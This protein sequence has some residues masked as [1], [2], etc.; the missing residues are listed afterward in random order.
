MNL[1]EFIRKND[2]KCKDGEEF[3]H[4]PEFFK[5]R[6]FERSCHTITGVP[7][8]ELGTYLVRD[9]DVV[10][11]GSVRERWDS[12]EKKTKRQFFVD[13]TFSYPDQPDW[14]ETIEDAVDAGQT[15]EQ[16]MECMEIE[17]QRFEF[18]REHD[19]ID[20]GRYWLDRK[21]RRC[22]VDKGRVVVIDSNGDEGYGR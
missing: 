8:L 5:I 12:R 6:E 4:S 10:L 18:F 21:L 20:T 13:R 17:R 3:G 1:A 14:V 16:A 11:R 7:F 9:F 19:L 2:I 22:V 15:V